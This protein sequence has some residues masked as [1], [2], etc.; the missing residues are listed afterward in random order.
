MDPKG[1][2][3]GLPNFDFIEN[4]QLRVRKTSNSFR[5]VLIA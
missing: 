2:H 5:K 1:S 4:V 3:L